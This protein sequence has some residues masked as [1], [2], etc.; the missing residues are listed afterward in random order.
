MFALRM[1]LI[2]N[3]DVRYVEVLIR[4]Y[5]QKVLVDGSHVNSSHGA[6]M[7]VIVCACYCAWT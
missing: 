5:N 2:K 7:H 1:L 3:S 4:I 6:G